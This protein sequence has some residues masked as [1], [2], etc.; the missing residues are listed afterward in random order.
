M[1]TNHFNLLFLIWL[2]KSNNNGSGITI[3]FSSNWSNI[4]FLVK[5]HSEIPSDHILT[6]NPHPFFPIITPFTILGCLVIIDLSL[7]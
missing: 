6:C 5:E 3:P 2:S 1:D 4:S 7:Y